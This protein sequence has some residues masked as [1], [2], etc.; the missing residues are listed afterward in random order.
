MLDRENRRTGGAQKRPARAES[1]SLGTWARLY[2]VLSQLSP[3][4]AASTPYWQRM[5]LRIRNAAG[6]A[7]S[8][9]GP[10]FDARYPGIRGKG[11][12]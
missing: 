4:L 7:R 6:A 5:D 10:R 11:A 2:G 8:I 9:L 1:K 12:E 3:S